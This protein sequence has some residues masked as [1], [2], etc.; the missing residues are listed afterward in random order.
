MIYFEHGDN[1]LM[2]RIKINTALHHETFLF[3]TNYR[4]TLLPLKEIEI[5]TFLHVMC[6]HKFDLSP[7]HF[8]L[9]R[10]KTCLT[11]VIIIL[12][13]VWALPLNIIR[14]A[15]SHL[16]VQI[17]LIIFSFKAGPGVK[18]CVMDLL[19]EFTEIKKLG[20]KPELAHRLDR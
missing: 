10:V 1:L 11:L 2:Q 19:D 14:E 8:Q 15:N 7:P 16:I 6:H 18:I 5:F 20:Q 17:Y 13:M 4:N 12:L 9:P 3:P